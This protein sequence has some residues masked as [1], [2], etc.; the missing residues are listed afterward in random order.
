MLWRDQRCDHETGME[1]GTRQQKE[2]GRERGQDEDKM[3]RVKAETETQRTRREWQRN[4]RR[5]TNE[6]VATH[7][8]SG[9]YES[10]SR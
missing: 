10:G 8:V 9:A 5:R 1:Y 4:E 3:E 2:T 6:E 7:Y